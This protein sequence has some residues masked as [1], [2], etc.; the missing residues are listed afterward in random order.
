MSFYEM[1]QGVIND[2]VGAY[3]MGLLGGGSRGRGSF[4]QGLLN[5][6]SVQNQVMKRQHA[7]AQAER[8]A[9]QYAA[10]Q[11]WAASN[12]AGLMGLQPQ[13]EQ[14][15]GGLI[16]A[17]P[18]HASE[19]LLDARLGTSSGAMAK[20][21]TYAYDQNGNL[22]LGQMSSH[23][24]FVPTQLP[25][26][27][28]AASPY[29]YL[30]TG[31]AHV[32]A[33]KYLPGGGA[34]PQGGVMGPGGTPGPT[35][36]AIPI[37]NT[38][39]ALQKAVGAGGGADIVSFEPNLAMAD[40]FISAADETMGQL[41]GLAGMTGWDTTGFLAYLNKIPTSDQKSWENAKFSIQ[42]QI[43]LIKMGELKAQS[44]TGATGF[45]ALSGPELALLQGYLGKLDQTD[46]PKTIK[47][48]IMQITKQIE[49]MRNSAIKRRNRAISRYTRLRENNKIPFGY[50]IP[51]D[52]MPQPY[53][54]RPVTGQV[55][56]PGT[57]ED[58]YVYRGGDPADPQSWQKQ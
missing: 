27:W 4:D 21:P 58:G 54:P 3:G 39:P 15:V 20:Q 36:P 41:A 51:E 57:V 26:G 43:A 6:Q 34:A 53:D 33:P 46:D 18:A 17:N 25:Q 29:S 5:A 47:E 8:A 50:E 30:N 11:N 55:L 14:L 16:G 42:S 31:T 1:M 38:D 56:A 49:K 28:Q 40:G 9:E 23:G 37:N 44:Q 35:G 19:T 10:L 7:A 32:P 12:P 2:P 22:V 52:E 24:G 45:G 13:Q 48:T